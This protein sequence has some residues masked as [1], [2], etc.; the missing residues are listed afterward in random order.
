M[1]KAKTAPSRSGLG[2]VFKSYDGGITSLAFPL[3]LRRELVPLLRLVQEQP[4]VLRPLQT[5]WPH[6]FSRLRL[7]QVC[8]LPF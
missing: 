4:L 3:A 5:W 7:A 2:A 8:R 1:I 6:R